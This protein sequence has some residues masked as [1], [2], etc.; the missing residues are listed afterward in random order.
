MRSSDFWRAFASQFRVDPRRA[1]DPV[2]NRL[3][4]EVKPEWAVLDVGGGA[5]RFALPLAL[6]C[7][8]VTVVEPSAS[9]VE[10]LQQGAGAA[11]IGNLSIVQGTWEAVAV[12][13]AQ[14]VVCAHVLYTVGDVEPFVRKLGSHARERVLILMFMNAPQCHLSPLW[15]WVHGEE[16]VDLPGLRELLGVLWEM[17]IYP[18]LEMLQTSSSPVY[19]SWEGAQE[20]LR[21]RLY[22]GPG[23]E[24]DRR[25]E[26]AMEE[27]LE[28]TPD[29]FA[30]RGAAPRRLG[31]ISWRPQ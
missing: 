4:G 23:S 20:E 22:V 13:P 7:R 31:L 27:L 28:R 14:A 25:L 5:G 17:E 19:E 12:E 26:R 11:K 24:E 30:I 6:R 8:H 1:D 21:R 2:L 10:E 18:D 3:M 15:S 16:R 9:M 29:G